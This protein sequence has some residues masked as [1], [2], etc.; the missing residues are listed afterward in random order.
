MNID[1]LKIEIEKNN[2]EIENCK[3]N[4]DKQQRKLKDLKVYIF[5]FTGSLYFKSS[6][7]IF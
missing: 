6:F 4:I 2:Q 5:A 3:E 7:F 1:K